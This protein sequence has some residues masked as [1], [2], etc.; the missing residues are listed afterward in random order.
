[1]AR[2]VAERCPLAAPLSLYAFLIGLALSALFH[3]ASHR[4]N[5]TSSSFSSDILWREGEVDVR[6]DGNV[7]GALF[8]GLI[9]RGH[10]DV[11]VWVAIQHKL[12][13]VEAPRHE[14]QRIFIQYVVFRWLNV[15]R[16]NIETDHGSHEGHSDLFL[17]GLLWPAERNFDRGGLTSLE[18][19]EELRVIQPS[20]RISLRL[21]LL[22][23]EMATTRTP[24]LPGGGEHDVA[25]V[26]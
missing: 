23:V 4:L 1:M 14:L 3:S 8:L 6:R 25:A 26:S 24:L 12:L 20:E 19:E 10:D 18:L 17:P 16:V 15:S 11:A 13:V 5:T 9:S 22:V 7:E 21:K 2:F